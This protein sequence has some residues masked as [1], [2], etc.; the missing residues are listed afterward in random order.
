MHVV[1]IGGGAAGMAAAIAAAK[2]GRR[3]TVLERGRRALK[4]LGVTGN[5]RGN[6]LNCGEPRYFGDADFA[7]Q[8]LATMPYERIAAFL[9]EAGIPLVHEAEGRMYP[10][11]YLAAS[12]VD[13]LKWQADALGV[14]TVVNTR[15][16]RIERTDRGFA[17]HARKTNFAPDITLKSG[18]V[19]PGEAI[20]EEQVRYDCDRVIV[21]VGGAAAAV[22]G[23]DGSAYG[24]LTDLGHAVTEIHPA[25]TALTTDK[26]AVEGLS[27]QRVRARLALCD[28]QGK[29]LHQS[30]GEALFAEDGV[31]GIAAMQLSRFASAGCVLHM[32]LRLAVTGNADA[33][34]LSWLK[35]RARTRDQRTLL[36]GAASP[37]LAAALWRR[38]GHSLD[39]LAEVIADFTVPV[40]GVR[41]FDSAQVTAGGVKTAAFDPSTMES[42]LV[43][44]VYA[45]GEVL[46][47]DGEC[48]GYNLMF[49]FA[50]GLLAGEH[51]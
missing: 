42:R 23:T 12:A 20:G 6:L 10:S 27:G 9:E 40:T 15:A 47:V 19:K 25:L 30:E 22:H 18:R 43:P 17:V 51:E 2:H 7:A 48:G 21:T 31:S 44:G 49:A 8:V 13:A 37:A 46:D 3:V 5:G 14:E 36:T 32:D 4:K 41:G 28:A 16:V 50:S 29:L 34:A 33:D 45:A 1:I 11:S 24:L 39:R 35:N 26:K 38:S